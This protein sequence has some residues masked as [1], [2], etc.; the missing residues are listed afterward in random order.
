VAKNHR[1]QTGWRRL[2]GWFA[3]YLLVLHIFVAGVATGHSVAPDTAGI[4]LCLSHADEGSPPTDGPSNTLGKM[5]C[6]FCPATMH[7]NATIEVPATLAVAFAEA[8]KSVWSFDQPS[9]PAALEC[10]CNGARA[11]PLEV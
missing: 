10:L 8:S 9:R 6:A 2:T 4:T 7:A 5:H 3:A 1:N 11:P